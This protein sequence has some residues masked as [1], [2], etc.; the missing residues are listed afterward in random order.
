M[1]MSSRRRARKFSV[2]PKNMERE[3]MT[4]ERRV[5]GRDQKLTG[6]V[7]VATSDFLATHL[8]IPSL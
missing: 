4:L 5:V 2:P 7:R 6:H 3:V 8:L 1:D